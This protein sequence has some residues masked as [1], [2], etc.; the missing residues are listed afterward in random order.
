MSRI[1]MFLLFPLAASL[2]VAGET[3]PWRF[4]FSLQVNAPLD[5]LRADTNDRVGAGAS[6]LS[7]YY[8]TPKHAL[9]GRMDVDGFRLKENHDDATNN[10]DETIM[11]RYGVGVD[12]LF[13]P[14]GNQ[15]RG[16]FL[17][18]GLGVHRWCLDDQHWLRQGRVTPKT[19][20]TKPP[21]TGLSAAASVGF[22]FTAVTAVELRASTSPYDRPSRG[23]LVDASGDTAGSRGQGQ[24]IQLAASFRW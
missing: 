14:G 9:R 20:T 6:F 19:L 7:S 8:L 13:F 22:Q 23:M 17:S 18:A 1:R 21:R 4:G 3:R 5:D 10:H 24:M 11:S 15:R 12:Y 2:A 16:V